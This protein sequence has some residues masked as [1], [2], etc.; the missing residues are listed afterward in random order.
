VALRLQHLAHL[1]QVGAD[2][3]SSATVS[4]AA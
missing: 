3:G 4:A 1:L 2:D